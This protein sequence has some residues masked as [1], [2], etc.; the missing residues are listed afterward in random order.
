M[1][2]KE[3]RVRECVRQAW[4]RTPDVSHPASEGWVTMDTA[5]DP[6]LMPDLLIPLKLHLCFSSSFSLWLLSC[7]T[8]LI[9]M[10]STTLQLYALLSSVASACVHQFLSSCLTP[11][12]PLPSKHLF[13]PL[14]G[15]LPVVYSLSATNSKH[16]A[17][18]D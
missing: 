15:W 17:N 4:Q 12:A 16:Y 8:G 6:A 2:K 3:I 7:L 14:N 13:C 10:R 9:L 1:R 11:S 5:T 18:L